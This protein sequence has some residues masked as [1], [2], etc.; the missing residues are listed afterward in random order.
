M[1]MR[2]IVALAG[3]VT[4]LPVH[5]LGRW[6]GGGGSPEGSAA[7]RAEWSGALAGLLIVFSPL[8]NEGS[9]AAA[10]TRCSTAS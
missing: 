1:L 7:G 10:G 9:P 2:G 8:Y 3:A 6:L 5:A 4:V